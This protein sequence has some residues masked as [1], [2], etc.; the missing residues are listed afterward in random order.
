MTGKADIEKYKNT[1][2]KS[3]YLF[4]PRTVSKNPDAFNI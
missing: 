2:N 4:T 3:E 1:E